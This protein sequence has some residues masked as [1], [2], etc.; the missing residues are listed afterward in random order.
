MKKNI[1]YLLITTSLIFCQYAQPY[2]P[3]D[4]VSIPTAGTLP[5]GHYSLENIFTKDGGILPKFSIGITDNFTLGISYGLHNFIGTGSIIKNKEYPEVQ[6]KYRIF[7]ETE[8][9]PGMVIGLDTQGRGRYYETV[10]TEVDIFDGDGD[11]IGSNLIENDINR[12]DQK[13]IGLYFVI[14]RNW[15]S[16][17]NFGIHAGI[18]KNLTEVDD[19]D[20]D[21]NLFF[22]FDK[23]LNR[24]F[25]LF[26]EYN[27]AL[28]DDGQ[29]GTNTE[30]EELIDTDGKGYLNA[31]L[32]WSVTDNL[33]LEVN[34]NDL[35]KNNKVEKSQNR[36]LKVIFF[37][38]F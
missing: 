18:S 36:E 8:T 16:L 11:V 27:F 33:M 23:E 5:R 7:D 29:N 34:V 17:G 28:N 22:G 15:A 30:F 20:N 31:G 21:I 35:A 4:L 1:I 9:I 25:S 13:A 3:L 10:T 37:E 24:S 2:P 14:S 32:R 19:K 38:Q 6:L 12:Y 26:A